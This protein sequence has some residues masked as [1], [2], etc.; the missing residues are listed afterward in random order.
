MVSLLQRQDRREQM[1]FL[2]TI[3]GLAWAV[4]DAIPSTDPSV[5]HILDW[6]VKER[7]Q[8]AERLE[9]TIDASSNFR[10]PREIDAWSV[11]QG[12]L[13][14]SG[15]DSWARK[16]PPSTKPK[17]PSNPAARP[18]LT[19]A[20]EDHSVPALMDKTP[21][22]MVLSPAKISCWYSHVSAI[23]QF[24]DRTD[25]HIDDVAVILEDDIDMEMDTADRLSQVWT[26]LPAGWDIVFLG[27]CWSNESSYPALTRPSSH[28]S[29]DNI[30]SSSI[31]GATN[32]HPSFAPKCTHAYALSLSGAR[33]LLQHL[34]YP[35]FA[36]SRALDQAYAWLIRSGRLRS[37][38]V[39]PSVVV[40]RKTVSSDIL[41]GMGSE[42]R[43]GLQNGVF[44]S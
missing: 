43:E 3:Q 10:W 6:V 9:T 23:R 31:E 14:G 40:Q 13:E 2:S 29:P 35:P 28:A 30:S 37:Y 4:I 27:H 24:V 12:P 7:E 44:G 22:W 17:D 11:N 39:V 8:L 5:N 34:R 41:P 42:W 16:G 33:R 25:A 18:N 21:E 15:S 19:C 32:L 36:Y 1:E 38:S 20:A 26:V